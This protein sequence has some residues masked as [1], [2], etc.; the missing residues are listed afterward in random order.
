MKSGVLEQSWRIALETPHCT[1]SVG[2]TRVSAW[3]MSREP[4]RPFAQRSCFWTTSHHLLR[5][6][7]GEE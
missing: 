7:R 5:K 2:Q 4:G 1:T 6:S 3:A